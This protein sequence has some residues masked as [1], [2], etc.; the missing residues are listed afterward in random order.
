MAVRGEGRGAKVGRSIGGA[1]LRLVAFLPSL[2]FV[3]S[4][5]GGEGAKVRRRIGGAN[6]RLVACPPS[7]LFFPLMC[8]VH[9][10]RNLDPFLMLDEFDGGEDG[11]GFPDH[12]HR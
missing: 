11:A 12:P 1:N 2:P 9:V 8:I 6:V 3:G 5:R 10:F 4:P 7:L